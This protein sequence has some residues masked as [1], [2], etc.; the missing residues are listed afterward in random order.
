[1]AKYFRDVAGRTRVERVNA[2][3]EIIDPVAGFSYRL[4]PEKQV[5][6]RAPIEVKSALAQAASAP[7]ASAPLPAREWLGTQTIEGM[8]TYGERFTITFPAGSSGANRPTK[9]VNEYWRS[10]QLGID[11]TTRIRTP[12]TPDLITTLKDLK[13]AEPDAALFRIPSDYRIVDDPA[14]ARP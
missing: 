1:M 7:A 13:F 2:G 4:D 11:M 10:P 14:F 8:I 5:A 6:V 12:R 3:V 9:N